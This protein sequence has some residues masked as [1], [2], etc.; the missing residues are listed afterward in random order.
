[1]LARRYSDSVGRYRHHDLMGIVF[2]PRFLVGFGRC[3]A[4]LDGHMLLSVMEAGPC[5]PFSR[6]SIQ[7]GGLG[8]GVCK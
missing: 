4:F 1:M 2:I 3:G 5:R 7:S 6:F 8:L